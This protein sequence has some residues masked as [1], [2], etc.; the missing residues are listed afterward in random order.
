MRITGS[1]DRLSA[2][3]IGR[4][5]TSATLRTL[6]VT[7][8]GF[9]SPT[10]DLMLPSGEASAHLF[11]HHSCCEADGRS[12]V[13]AI[14]AGGTRMPRSAHRAPALSSV[15][16]V[17]FIASL[18]TSLGASPVAAATSLPDGTRLVTALPSAA[19]VNTDREGGGE[20]KGGE[21]GGGRDIEKK[22]K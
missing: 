22:K 12:P 7:R 8:S 4:H 3:A 1:I 14:V 11:W 5:R 18:S 13:N 16:V 10:I 6:G 21:L 9:H 2:R 20:G 15:M 17:L 19:P